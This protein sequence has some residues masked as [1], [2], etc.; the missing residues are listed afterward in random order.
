[1]LAKDIMTTTVITVGPETEVTE[2]AKTLTGR[3]ISAVPVVDPDGHIVGIVSEGDLIRRAENGTEKERGSWWLTLFTEPEQLA[4]EYSKAHGRRADEVMTRKVITVT[5]ETPVAEIA[6]ILAQNHIK[7]VPVLRDG[8]VVGIVSRANLLHGLASATAGTTET[9]DASDGT[10][11]DEVL[12][13]LRAEPWVQRS[14]L[15]VTVE[16]GVAH[17]WGMADNGEQIRAT[18]VVAK[19]TPGVIT[20]ENHMSV[21]EPYMY[22][23]E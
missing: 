6:G 18:E 14:F 5:V 9:V 13:K 22:Y 21:I 17:L 15:N 7:R 3:R 19:G 12:E 11:R 10:I 1:M 16:N 23:G 2:I 8:V 20:V 4:K